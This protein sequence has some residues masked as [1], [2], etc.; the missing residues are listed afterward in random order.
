MAGGFGGFGDFVCVC[1]AGGDDEGL[2]GLGGITDKGEVGGFKGGDFVGGRTEFFQHVYGGEIKGGAENRDALFAGVVKQGGVP[3]PRHMGFLIE[4]VQALPAP[5][6]AVYHEF[7]SAGGQGDGVGGVALDFD[8]IC[9]GGF[10]FFYDFEGGLQAAV[11]VGGHL[12]NDVGRM[13]GADF[14]AVDVHGGTGESG[15]GRIL[16]VWMRERQPE[17]GKDVFRLPYLWKETFAKPQI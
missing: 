8:G 10:G 11:V 17:N 5:Q 2:A 3:V 4:L 14:A 15:K 1:H 16:R 6:A 13:G 9:A 12:G 7:G